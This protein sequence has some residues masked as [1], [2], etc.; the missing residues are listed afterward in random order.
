[1]KKAHWLL[2]I[3]VIIMAMSPLSAA[4]AQD[5][6]Q[7]IY[8]VIYNGTQG[9][10]VPNGQLVTL[11]VYTDGS[12]SGQY[13]ANAD[14]SG[15]FV[16]ENIELI[17]GDE[18]VVISDYAGAVYSAESFVYDSES[19][20]PD[21]SIEIFEATEDS[22]NVTVAQLT[23][24]LNASDGQLR[25]GEY[26][27][28]S[29]VGDKTWIGTLD[30]NLGFN[31]TV[32][33]SLPTEAE[34]LWFSGYGLDMRFFSVA[35]GFVDTIPVSPGDP[36]MEVFFSYAIPFTGKYEMSKTLNVPVDSVEFLVASESGIVVQGEG[37]EYSE[38]IQTDTDAALSY[39]SDAFDAGENF[40]FSVVEQSA[41]FFKTS[42]GLELAIGLAVVVL[43]GLGIYLVMKGSRKDTLPDCADPLII[44]IAH[45]DDAYAAGELKRDQ[46]QKKRQALI[47]QV[48]H[49]K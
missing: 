43:A 6:G 2:L 20:V 30:E 24:M 35:D 5:N 36:S 39:H 40:S 44:E 21:L 27:L 4:S 12:V 11:Y 37:L 45:L 10:Q 22:S 32:K 33:F 16:F 47:A 23:F 1:M 14:S 29:N 46:Y 38:T 17:N 34:S 9:G 41:G 48:K 18:V 7:T 19:E 3:V 42:L 15:V 25:V 31:T 13:S 28:I 8:G 26:Y 49:M